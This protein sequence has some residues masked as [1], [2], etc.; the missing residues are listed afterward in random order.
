MKCVIPSLLSKVKL[1]CSPNI[2]TILWLVVYLADSPSGSPGTPHSPG[3]ESFGSGS[4]PASPHLDI[5]S[6]VYSGPASPLQNGSAYSGSPAHSE[7]QSD[8]ASPL[9]VGDNESV[10]TNTSSP[11]V[12]PLGSE[13]GIPENPRGASEDLGPVSPPASPDG[14]DMGPASPEAFEEGPASPTG[15]NLGPAS[16]GQSEGSQ[17]QSNY[18]S[19][20]ASPTGSYAGESPPA[21]PDGSFHGS[22]PASPMSVIETHSSAPASPAEVEYPASPA[23]KFICGSPIYL[24]Y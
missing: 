13:S 19:A 1:R 10:H 20:P 2:K 16:P 22:P 11:P 4:N 21:S 12:S 7:I 9:G 15:S 6:P 8:P 18:G 3:A 5:P 17:G 23:G 14:S 24:K